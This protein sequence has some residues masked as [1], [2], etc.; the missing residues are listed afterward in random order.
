MS[1]SDWLPPLLY[2]V[3]VG[4][5]SNLCVSLYLHR[6]ITHGGVAFHPALAQLLRLWLWLTTGIVTREWVAV[7]RKHHAFVDREGDPHSPFLEGVAQVVLGGYFY[8][9]RA[10]GDPEL[11]ERYGRGCPDDWV[12]RH[13]YRL[14]VLGLVIMLVPAVALFGW[15]IGFLVWTGM[16]LWTPL[17]G[18]I[19]NGLGHAA[20][21]RNF[22][23]RDRS[24]NLS[25]IGFWVAG[26][27]L[28]NN[29][30]ADPRSA[31]FRGYW[32]ELD[33]G[34][35]YIRILSFLGL[36]RVIYART[37]SVDEFRLRHFE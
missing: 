15:L 18:G 29:H 27:E 9:R 2:T 12:E 37:A 20:G 4:H 10:A 36:A 22:E 28:H 16:V 24:R 21:Y 6:G 25:P 5:L 26:E 14:R 35:V 23:T 34:W 32:W 3:A 13:L 17:A 11:I 33:I 31:R 8:Y 30:H 19:I 7:H 1:I